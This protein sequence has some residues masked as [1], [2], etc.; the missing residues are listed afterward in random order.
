MIISKRRRKVNGKQRI[1]DKRGGAS[2]LGTDS[3]GFGEV[4]PSP[5]EGEGRISTRGTSVRNSGEGWCLRHDT[6]LDIGQ[7]INVIP[8]LLR[9]LKEKIRSRNKCGMT[10]VISLAPQGRGKKG[11]GLLHRPDCKILKR[12][13]DDRVLSKAHR[14]E[15]NVLTSY[16]LNDFKKKI[17]FTLAEVLITL[18]IIGVVAAMTIPTLMANY[19][20]KVL[21]NQFKKTYAML[22]QALLNAQ[23]QLGYFPRCYYS[24]DNTTIPVITG[25]GE[26]SDKFWTLFKVSKICEGKA[27]EKGCIPEYEGMDTVANAN[28]PDAEVPDGYEDYG[29]YASRGCKNFKKNAILNDRTVYVLSDGTIIILYSEYPFLL[30]VDINGQKGPNKWGHDLFAFL[31]RFDGN[32]FKYYGGGCMYAEEGGLLTNTMITKLERN[33]L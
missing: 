30:A 17:A 26:L 23:S 33:K 13:Q 7:P 15:L 20:Q 22:N 29:D 4:L 1:F 14:K 12:V 5:L 3:K 24:V 8:H 10:K 32:K 27:F 25:C 21:N 28:Y 18:A 31:I 11:E 6:I 2:P 19:Q 9:D 16:R